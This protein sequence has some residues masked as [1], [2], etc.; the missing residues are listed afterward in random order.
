MEAVRGGPVV[1]FH[2]LFATYGVDKV[3]NGHKHNYGR[4]EVNG[5][6]YVVTA[7]ECVVD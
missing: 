5:M 3:F 4:N 1:H 2:P 6:T 7:G